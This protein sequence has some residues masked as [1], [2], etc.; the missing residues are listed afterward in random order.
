MEKEGISDYHRQGNHGDERHLSVHGEHEAQTQHQQDADPDQVRHL[1]RDKVPGGFNVAG[2][3]LDHIPGVIAHMP[4]EGEP[5]NMAE[6]RIPHGFDQPLAGLGVGYTEFI[7]RRRADRG[8]AQHRHRHDPHPLAERF[9]TAQGC[10][11][12]LHRLRQVFRPFAAD[13][14]INGNLDDLRDD[15]F[16]KRGNRRTDHT[17]DE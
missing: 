10:Q 13:D 1:L 8:H 14:V 17:Q 3:P 7:P 12:A 6:K 16:R 15:H 4:L 9:R 11:Q 5:L 2:T